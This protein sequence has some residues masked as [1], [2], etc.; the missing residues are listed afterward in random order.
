MRF[1]GAISWCD[2]L[3]CSLLFFWAVVRSNPA[4]GPEFRHRDC[5]AAPSA[6]I[7]RVA[8]ERRMAVGRHL[9]VLRAAAAHQPADR[10]DGARLDPA[11]RERSRVGNRGDL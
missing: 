2:S 9:A 6:R 1:L 7:W 4:H 11:Y 10:P 5:E 3:A 8:A